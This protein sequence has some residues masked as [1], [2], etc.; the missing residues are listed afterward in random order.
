[1]KDQLTQNRHRNLSIL[2][3][4][5]LST[6]S[7]SLKDE[8][9]SRILTHV[10]DRGFDDSDLFNFIDGILNDKF[11]IRLKISRLIDDVTIDSSGKNIPI[12]MIKHEFPNKQTTVIQKLI[13]KNK[14]Y[15]D[16][17]RIVE[18]GATL[19]G[20]HLVKIQFLKRDGTPIFKQPMFLVT[21]HL[22]L[23]EDHALGVY[24]IYL[25]RSKIEGV[26]KFLKEVMG[27]EDFQVRDF[28]S[29]KNLLTLC[30]FVAG[31]FYEIEPLLLENEFAHFIAALGGGKG[32]V[33]RTYL[34]R[35]FEKLMTKHLVDTALKEADFSEDNTAALAAF[36]RSMIRHV[37]L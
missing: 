28:Q 37:P 31:Y 25:Q 5:K 19:N 13:L 8:N 3:Q 15:Q 4:K 29:I 2:T 33:T 7:N 36:A 35:G 32:K 27:W 17:K 26:F 18:Y 24:L 12:K 20:Y 23:T 34:L 30:Y 11:V 22:M 10:L 21:N 9:K 16:V 6:I 14:V 1:V